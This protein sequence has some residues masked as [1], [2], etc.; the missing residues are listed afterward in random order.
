MRRQNKFEFVLLVSSAHLGVSQIIT[1]LMFLQIPK[2]VST[3]WMKLMCPCLPFKGLYQSVYGFYWWNRTFFTGVGFHRHKYHLFNYVS[4]YTVSHCLV[5]SFK[6]H[7][8]P[9]V[10]KLHLRQ[11]LTIS[12]FISDRHLSPACG[13][14][15]SNRGYENWAADVV[16]LIKGPVTSL[17]S[18]AL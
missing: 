12:F 2:Q 16:I 3:D 9:I 8:F 11:K 13:S 7:I 10:N 18:W 14:V 1:N 17:N 15:S 4:T 5:M 6:C